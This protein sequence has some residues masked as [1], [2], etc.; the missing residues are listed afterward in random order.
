MENILLDEMIDN[1]IEEMKLKEELEAEQ[2]YYD[3]YMRSQYE[4]ENEMP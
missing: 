1:E 2:W 3:E 4:E